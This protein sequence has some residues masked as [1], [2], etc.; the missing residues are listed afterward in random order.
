MEKV[1]DVKVA[2]MEIDKIYNE[3]LKNFK[4]AM[5]LDLFCGEIKNFIK[6]VK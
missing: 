3:Q 2:L 1:K 6:A 5:R 4:P